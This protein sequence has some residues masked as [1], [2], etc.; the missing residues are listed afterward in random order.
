M[1]TLQG[2]PFSL[3]LT[4][5]L[6]LFLI[7]FVK[8]CSECSSQI[9]ILDTLSKIL[10]GKVFTLNLCRWEKACPKIGNNEVL[11]NEVSLSVDYALLVTWCY[12]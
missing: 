4:T 7:V 2:V 3:L 1:S 9:S 5:K 12:Y 8:W 11:T 6:L 10:L